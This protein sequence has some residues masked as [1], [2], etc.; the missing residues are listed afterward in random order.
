MSDSNL[1]NL[2]LGSHYTAQELEGFISTTDATI[3]SSNED[4]LFTD[5]EREYKVTHQFKGCFEQ[6]AED[7]GKRY[8]AQR[9][10]VVEKV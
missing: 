2:E 8:K 7:G 3:L 1:N 9:T 4:E 5:S 10:Y 6:A